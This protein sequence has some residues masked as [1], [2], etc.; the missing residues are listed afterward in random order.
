MRSFVTGEGE[1][2]KK[3]LQEVT[4]YANYSHTPT[5]IDMAR[6]DVVIFPKNR[7]Y[8]KNDSHEEGNKG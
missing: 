5:I 1:G 3:L 2:V 6:M 4:R 7:N 8:K